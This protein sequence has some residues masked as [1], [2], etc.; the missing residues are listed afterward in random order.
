MNEWKNKS[1][2]ANQNLLTCRKMN[3]HSHANIMKYK[4]FVDSAI[5]CQICRNRLHWI[6]ITSNKTCF[7]FFEQKKKCVR[8]SQCCAHHIVMFKGNGRTH[9]GAVKWKYLTIILFDRKTMNGWWWW[10]LW[11]PSSSTIWIMF[12]RQ[13]FLF[14]FFS[15][16]SLVSRVNRKFLLLI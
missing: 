4:L 11:S 15:S 6:A 3:R 8:V 12:Q 10:W 9:W 1:S 13:I 14:V 5:K 2:Y 16:S 7:L